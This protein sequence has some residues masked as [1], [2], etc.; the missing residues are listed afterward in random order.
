MPRRRAAR[1]CVGRRIGSRR[2]VSVVRDVGLVRIERSR[3]I[4]GCEAPASDDRK[5]EPMPRSRDRLGERIGLGSGDFFPPPTP[6][7][8]V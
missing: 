7:S 4:R 8:G 1:V 3:P 5:A 2:F 6:R